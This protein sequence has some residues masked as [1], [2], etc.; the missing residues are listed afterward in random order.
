MTPNKARHIL[1]VDDDPDVRASIQRAL[2]RAGYA[3][4]TAADGVEA[5]TVLQVE[6]VDLVL[7]DLNM[8][9]LSGIDLAAI[10]RVQ[11]PRL[12]IVG[13]SGQLSGDVVLDV[14]SAGMMAFLAKPVAPR[15][16]VH[17]VHE[18][19]EERS[20]LT[21]YAPA[22]EQPRSAHP[23]APDA[24]PSR[25]NELDGLLAEH[26][27]TSEIEVPPAQ[28]I[29]RQLLSYWEAPDQSA[30]EIRALVERSPTLASQILRLANS[31]DYQR[32]V[33]V[34]DI[35]SAVRR[36]G[37]RT[38]LSAAQT[39]L[40]QQFYRAPS[41]AWGEVF[42]E[43]WRTT[44]YVAAFVRELVKRCF[45]TIDSDDSYLAALFRD[46]AEPVLFRLAADGDAPV[47]PAV[48]ATL[49]ER[50]ELLH[51]RLGARILKRWGFPQSIWR[52]ARSH[53][54]GELGPREPAPTDAELR[55][56][57]SIRFAAHVAHEKGLVCPGAALMTP[58][59]PAW[60]ADNGVTDSILSACAERAEVAMRP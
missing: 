31:V 13:L 26:F 9:R 49:V 48:L 60:A 56:L 11:T 38:V 19:L 59:D 15:H 37:N 54:S 55:V 25:D 33:P 5:L 17:I 53:H 16:L 45:P 34:V 4:S 29:L 24:Q 40:Y 18:A 10:L 1:V 7:T 42:V 36:L 41:R 22:G 30:N 46:V 43:S 52:I 39:L 51:E 27:G 32:G 50:S 8:P 35:A 3:V 6:T 20:T 47:S 58:P 57:E 44:V 12:P 2:V 21:S 14:F 28:P 23:V